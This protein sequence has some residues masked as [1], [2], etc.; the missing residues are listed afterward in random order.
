MRLNEIE[1]QISEITLADMDR[2][3]FYGNKELNDKW[4][5]V[6]SDAEIVKSRLF[7]EL[8][9][10]INDQVSYMEVY[11]FKL[12]NLNIPIAYLEFTS[13]GMGWKV[14]IASVKESAAGSGL[15]YKMYVILIKELGKTLISDE[16]QSKGGAKIWY[17]LYKTPGI[18][19]YGWDPRAPKENRFFQVHDYNQDGILDGADRGMYNTFNSEPGD[20][21]EQSDLG[22]AS[23]RKLIAIKTKR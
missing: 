6:K 12:S 17:K 15:G 2:K 10:G 19:V 7:P 11:L 23:I 22:K 20:R 14:N 5:S 13:N 9:I 1:R 21:I 3:P 16:I 8:A 4:R 18:T